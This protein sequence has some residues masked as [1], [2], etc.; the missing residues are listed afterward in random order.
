MNTIR[1]TQSGSVL[2]GTV[3]SVF[4][5]KKFEYVKYRDW[6][7]NPQ[8]YGNELLLY[9]VPFKTIY[10]HDGNTEFLLKERMMEL[11]LSKIHC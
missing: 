2:E 10:G 8:K 9:N 5:K 7:K 1:Q 11:Q 6:K 4:L 3:K